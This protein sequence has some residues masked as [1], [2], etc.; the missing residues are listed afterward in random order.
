MEFGAGEI[1]S[2]RFARKKSMKFQIQNGIFSIAFDELKDDQE[3]EFA[4]FRCMMLL[5]NFAI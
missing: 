5:E 1:C 2:L 4:L 3:K